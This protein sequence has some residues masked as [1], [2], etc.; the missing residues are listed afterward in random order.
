MNAFPYS[1]H[2]SSPATV[3][4]LGFIIIQSNLLLT[5]TVLRHQLFRLY[6]Y[7]HQIA[8]KVLSEVMQLERRRCTEH[9]HFHV[10]Q[11]LKNILSLVFEPFPQQLIRRR[12]PRS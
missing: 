5:H 9:T 8:H 10:V 1:Q 12:K 7:F 4:K 11:A 2:W 3:H 6:Q